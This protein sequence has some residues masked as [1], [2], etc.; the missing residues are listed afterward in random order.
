[1]SAA[2]AAPVG[3]AAPA[4]PADAPSRADQPA[5]AAPAAATAPASAAP[6]AAP[7][8]AGPVAPTTPP[9]VPAPAALPAALVAPGHTARNVERLNDLVQVATSR[10]V[11][12][13]RLELHPADLGA[14]DVR[15]RQTTQGLV[16]SIAV[17]RPEALQAVTQAGDQLRQSLEDRGL[18]LAQ[19]DISLAASGDQAGA[20]REPRGQGA[21]SGPQRPDADNDPDADDPLTSID[22]ATATTLP[23]GVLVDVH[24]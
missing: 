18:V 4:L 13:A 21:A 17:H 5:P 24:A 16:A 3:V 15:L 23:A 22:P 6:A 20:Y 1:V 14:I 12:R 19:L 11:S 8:T 10:G 7:P 9:T 2:P